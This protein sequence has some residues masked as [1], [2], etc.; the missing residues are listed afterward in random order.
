MALHR[1]HHRTPCYGNYLPGNRD[2]GDLPTQE[3]SAALRA[4]MSPGVGASGPLN[5]LVQYVV[6]RP[7]AL[8]TRPGRR[9]AA[10]FLNWLAQPPG[11]GIG[12]R[13]PKPGISMLLSGR[14]PRR[15][16]GGLTRA[17]QHDDA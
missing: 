7:P 1:S 16:R 3:V 15:H 11:G 5:E 17:N 14:P 4:R 13:S 10:R 6:E 12:E 8:E 9:R 2:G